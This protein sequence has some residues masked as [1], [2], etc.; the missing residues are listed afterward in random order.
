MQG[1]FLAPRQFQEASQ[2]DVRGADLKNKES[3]VVIC[4]PW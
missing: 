4:L 1:Y 3:Q 2:R